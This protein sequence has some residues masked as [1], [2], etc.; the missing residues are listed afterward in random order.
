MDNFDSSFDLGSSD[1]HSF[2]QHFDKEGN[3]L[4]TSIRN[5]HGGKD[6]FDSTGNLKGMT[7]DNIFD[8][9]SYVDNS[10]NHLGDTIGGSLDDNFLTGDGVHHTPPN[11]LQS[12]EVAD[13]R[14]SILCK[15]K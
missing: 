11:F 10:F 5:I 8:G 4:G 3:I 14:G 13:M 9:H 2:H 12:K 1:D 15:I 7:V 6:Y